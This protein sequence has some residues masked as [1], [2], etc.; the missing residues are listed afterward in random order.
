MHTRQ[1]QESALSPAQKMGQGTQAAVCMIHSNSAIQN[2]VL[3]ECWDPKVNLVKDVFLVHNNCSQTNPEPSSKLKQEMSPT[4]TYSGDLTPE[5]GFP[6]IGIGFTGLFQ[7]M[8]RERKP[9]QKRKLRRQGETD[10]GDKGTGCSGHH[11]L[12]SSIGKQRWTSESSDQCLAP[13]RTHLLSAQNMSWVTSVDNTQQW[14]RSHMYKTQCKNQHLFH[15][16]TPC[17]YSY[18]QLSPHPNTSN[19]WGKMTPK[20]TSLVK[21][22]FWLWLRN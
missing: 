21:L 12:L 20:Y 11:S 3:A 2:Q 1:L 13:P 4:T 16:S 7:Q 5:L 18:T 10:H 22:A 17:L 9:T 19:L 6:M 14:V 15:I 8:G